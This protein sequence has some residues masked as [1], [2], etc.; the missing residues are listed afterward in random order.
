VEGRKETATI[1]WRYTCGG[2]ATHGFLDFSPVHTIQ[3]GAVGSGSCASFC[4]HWSVANWECEAD[5][6]VF[7][8]TMAVCYCIC[9]GEHT[10]DTNTLLLK[11]S[12]RLHSSR[13]KQTMV[14]F[15]H[16]NQ[17]NNS[18]SI[19][20]NSQPG[21]HMMYLFHTRTFCTCK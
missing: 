2:R 13:R 5:L 8:S 4:L 7:E 11:Q 3:D 9:H 17:G 10:S 16:I 1:R 21:L 6:V 19:V 15:G 12:P 14:G 20:H 18:D